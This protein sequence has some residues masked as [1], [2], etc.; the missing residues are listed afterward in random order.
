VPNERPT[1]SW[2]W[3]FEQKVPSVTGE[4][5]LGDHLWKLANF[6]DPK[7]AAIGEVRRSLAHLGTVS[8][9]RLQRL[10]A[11]TLDLCAHR[12]DAWITSFATKRLDSMRKED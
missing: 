9:A 12:L 6:T 7:V 10:F 8:S 11:G 5:T 1:P 3:Q 2:R 4:K